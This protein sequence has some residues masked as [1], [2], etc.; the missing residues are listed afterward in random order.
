MIETKE[1]YGEL[2][3]KRLLPKNGPPVGTADHKAVFET[4]EALR[5]VA[6]AAK[7]ADKIL[8]PYWMGSEFGEKPTDKEIYS[9]IAD[10]NQALAKL[11]ADWI[12]E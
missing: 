2:Q 1:Q 3:M 4:I 12:T 9:A 10:L 7:Q 5:K 11:E 8:M 6:R